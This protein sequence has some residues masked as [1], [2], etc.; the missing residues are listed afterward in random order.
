MMEFLDP[1]Q[2]EEGY[3]HLCPYHEGPM[4]FA[5]CQNGCDEGVIHPFEDDLD[6]FNDD[7]ERCEHCR[8]AGGTWECPACIAEDLGL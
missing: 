3:Q 1:L 4:G 6:A 7:E 2:D 8:G 5:P